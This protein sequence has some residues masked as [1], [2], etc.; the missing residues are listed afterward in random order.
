MKYLIMIVLAYLAYRLFA[1]PSISPPRDQQPSEPDEE[2]Y[3]D[4]EEVD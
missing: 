2:E 3:T 1:Q 4:Y